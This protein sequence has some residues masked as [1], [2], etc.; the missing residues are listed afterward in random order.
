VLAIVTI[1]ES[2][3]PGTRLLKGNSA[4]LSVLW[5]SFS[6]GLNVMVTSMICFRIL[7]MRALTRELHS[8]ELS[9]MYTSIATM[10][11]ESAVPFSILGIC[12]IV[13]VIQDVPPKF[14]FAYVWSVFCVESG[15]LS[16]ADG[17]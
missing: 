15:F 10:L 13:T 6:V 9:S 17:D 3:M 14:A 2:T 1:V 11:I 12:L 4:L 5:Y 8:P 16:P 7:R